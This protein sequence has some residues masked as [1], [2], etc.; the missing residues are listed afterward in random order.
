MAPAAGRAASSRSTCG[1]LARRRTRSA[2]C[3]ASCWRPAGCPGV[4]RRG[5]RPR[6]TAMTGYSWALAAGLALLGAAALL[7]LTAGARRERR[8]RERERREREAREAWL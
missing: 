8:E 6:G 4:P 5:R 3:T 2:S 7:D 1:C